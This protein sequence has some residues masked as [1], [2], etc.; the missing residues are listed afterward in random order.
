M[1]MPCVVCEEHRARPSRRGWRLGNKLVVV[2]TEEQVRQFG[3][4][5]QPLE[6]FP[7]G[8]V[9]V[10]S[11][12]GPRKRRVSTAT[13]FGAT[14]GFRMRSQRSDSHE[15]DLDRFEL[16]NAGQLLDAVVGDPQLPQRV[17]NTIQA[18][19]LFDVVPP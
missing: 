1:R 19:N 10:G 7:I 15:Q 8:N 11:A 4:L 5:F 14:L 12:G 17:R 18:L 3:Q 2:L 9:V 6:L 13:S 16:L